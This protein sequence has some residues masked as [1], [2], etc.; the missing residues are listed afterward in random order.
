M[1]SLLKKALRYIETLVEIPTEYEMWEYLC[2]PS[3]TE[4]ELD[5]VLDYLLKIGKIQPD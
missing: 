3:V 5:D 1:N 4:K 2:H